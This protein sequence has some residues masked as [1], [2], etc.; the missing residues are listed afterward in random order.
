MDVAADLDYCP[1]TGD[2]TGRDRVGLFRLAWDV[3]CSAFGSRHVLYER[4]FFGDPSRMACAPYDA[5]ERRPLVA[6]V[7]G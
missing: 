5:Y 4:F 2:A 1:A 3:G 7:C 6:R